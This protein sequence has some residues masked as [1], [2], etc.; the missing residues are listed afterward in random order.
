[1]VEPCF[2]GIGSESDLVPTI[3][4]EHEREVLICQCTEWEEVAAGLGQG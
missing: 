1:M 2:H 4:A 3:D